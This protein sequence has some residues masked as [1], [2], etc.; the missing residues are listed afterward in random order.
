MQEA[1]LLHRSI[2]QQ[3]STPFLDKENRVDQS[4]LCLPRGVLM[5]PKAAAQTRCQATFTSP[6]P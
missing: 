5:C 2:H 4:H 1:W 6:A 3:R